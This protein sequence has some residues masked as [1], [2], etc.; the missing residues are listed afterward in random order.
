LILVLCCL[1]RGAILS[2]QIARVFAIGLESLLG[3]AMVSMHGD[4]AGPSSSQEDLAAT[5][6]KCISN[7]PQGNQS[8]L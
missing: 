5:M 1:F 6:K 3:I 4:T 2:K 8:L 7:R